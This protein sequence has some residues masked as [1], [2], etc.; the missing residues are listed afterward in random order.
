MQAA[1]RL[2]DK[3]SKVRPSSKTGEAISYTIGQWD[4]IARYIDYPDLTP[5]YYG[6]ERALKP[7]V[8]GRKNWLYSGSPRGAEASCF[9]FSMIETAKQND[10]EPFWYL[11]W[12]I[13]QAVT[14]GSEMA[15][16]KFLPWNMDREMVGAPL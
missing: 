10:I 7:F 3:A 9:F 15:P 1:H 11:K 6:A 13:E 16:E 4:K 5:D 12:L 14:M 2:N 8:I